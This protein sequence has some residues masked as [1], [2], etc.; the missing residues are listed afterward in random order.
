MRQV[1][2]GDSGKLCV[3]LEHPVR[4]YAVH[5]ETLLLE[6]GAV[7]RKGVITLNLHLFVTPEERE[8]LEGWASNQEDNNALLSSWLLA[9]PSNASR[10]SGVTNKCKFNVI[11]P[12]R[13]TA[14]SSSNNVSPCTAYCRTGCSNST[15]NL[16]LSPPATCRNR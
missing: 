9:H 10:S 12:F 16:P 6:D 15:H 11:T 8:A 14:P 3:E 2:G 1:A 7:P 13:G 4:Q 5:G